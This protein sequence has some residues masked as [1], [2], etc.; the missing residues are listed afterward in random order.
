MWSKPINIAL[1]NSSR[2]RWI[3]HPGAT[4]HTLFAFSGHS[5][6][7]F[8][9]EVPS[10]FDGPTCINWSS[11]WASLFKSASML[12]DS[13]V[14]TSFTASGLSI[15]LIS[16]D[17]PSCN[18]QIPY[19]VSIDSS[20]GSDSKLFIALRL[21]QG[22]NE[23]LLLWLFPLFYWWVTLGWM[24]SNK[25]QSSL[26]QSQYAQNMVKRYEKHAS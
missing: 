10:T 3:Q 9:V 22:R 17:K 21:F 15:H 19:L 13:S 1:P 8:K 14:C 26:L 12:S 4:S 23:A 2:G 6:F 25:L 24:V 7:F 11:L 18:D 5:T 16:S 20:T